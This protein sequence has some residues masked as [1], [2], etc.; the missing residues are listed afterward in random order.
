MF[1]QIASF[2]VQPDKLAALM[3]L[4]MDFVHSTRQEVGVNFYV[5][6][7]KTEDSNT[8]IVIEEFANE[9]AFHAHRQ[10]DHFKQA[11]MLFRD[12][13]SDEPEFRQYTVSKM[14]VQHQP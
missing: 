4:L 8:V 14:T 3:P 10:Q 9:A 13:L 5:P 1:L 7:S 12:Y 6:T 2:P 11:V